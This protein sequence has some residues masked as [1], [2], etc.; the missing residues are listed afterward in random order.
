M[1]STHTVKQ[2]ETLPKIAKQYGF[3][4]WATIYEHEKNTDFKQKRPNPHVIAP[5]DK[6]F[7]PDKTPK[8]TQ[9][10]TGTTHE[11]TLKTRL[12]LFRTALQDASKKPFAGK[13]YKLTAGEKTFEGT[14]DGQGVVERQIAD[15]VEE[16]SL[17]VWLD[18]DPP[19]KPRTFR[20]KVGHLDPVDTTTGVQARLKN[21]GYDCGAVDGTMSD[22]TKSALQAFQKAQGLTVD[23]TAND[24]TKQ[25]LVEAHGS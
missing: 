13:K 15:D 11:F 20:M 4:D 2:G 14:T 1:S 7:I 23:G 22:K 3:Y 5:G 24:E 8:E 25:K 6:I 21:L 9:G 10:A 17:S 12:T 16:V 18:G 19:K